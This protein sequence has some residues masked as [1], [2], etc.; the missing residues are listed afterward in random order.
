MGLFHEQ[1]SLLNVSQFFILHQIIYSCPDYS[2][3]MISN[4]AHFCCFRCV[5]G[6]A[7]PTSNSVLLGILRWMGHGHTSNIWFN[8][9]SQHFHSPSH[10]FGSTRNTPTSVGLLL[11]CTGESD[12]RSFSEWSLINAWLS[13]LSPST[14]FSLLSPPIIP[15]L[16]LFLTAPKAF[17]SN[18]SYTRLEEWY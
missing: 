15:T 2:E 16:L 14:S 7:K 8:R 17:P 12:H 13:S 3:L 5:L 4:F 1:I 11:R 10:L 9:H 6:C 18:R